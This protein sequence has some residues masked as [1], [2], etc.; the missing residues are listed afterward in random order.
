[1]PICTRS[2]WKIGSTHAAIRFFRKQCKYAILVHSGYAFLPVL[3]LKTL[4]LTHFSFL[5]S[6]GYNVQI[7]VVLRVPDPCDTSAIILV[8]TPSEE[9]G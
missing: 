4:Y 5:V 1:M 6:G 3:R 7:Q 2:P 8:F 9:N